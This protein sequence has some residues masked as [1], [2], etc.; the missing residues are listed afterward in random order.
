MTTAHAM[1]FNDKNQSP[2]IAIVIA[3]PVSAFL[4]MVFFT[5]YS[6][7]CAHSPTYNFDNGRR[8]RR[9]TRG[10]DPSVFETF[11]IL[12]YSVVKIH[13][14]GKCDLECAVCLNEFEDSETLRLIPNCDHVFHPECIDEW[15]ASHTTCP[16]CRANLAPQP[17]MP[18][19]GNLEIQNDVVLTVTRQQERD[20]NEQANV[21]LVNQTLNRIRTK[22]SRSNRKS[23]F[24]KSYST[25]HSLIEPGENT[26]RFTLKLPLD[27]REKI[28][29][30][31][32]LNRTKSMVTSRRDKSDRFVKVKASSLKSPR[33]TSS[34]AASPK[35][36][37][38]ITVD[39]ARLPV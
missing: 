4:L 33:V 24:P 29:Q 20:R 10:L 19:H 12:E 27:V 11:P 2:A 35:L 38:P 34:A 8:F 7:Y 37:K 15:F 5:I 32:E 6:R 31:R 25:G 16:V 13:K 3:I 39:S 26:E 17:V 21:I 9:M 14:I 36:P 1:N 22:R 18:V 28:I 30:N 23:Q